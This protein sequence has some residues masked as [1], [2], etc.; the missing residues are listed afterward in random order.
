MKIY[1]A[2]S[3]RAGRGDAPWYARCVQYLE[4]YGQI[5]TEH[6]GDGSL[7]ELGE[8]GKDDNLGHIHS[9]DMA[10]LQT[11]DVVVAEVS[12]PSLGVGYEIAS[13]IFLKK[14]VL[15]LYRIQP[16]T[17]LSGMLEGNPHIAITQFST[18]AQALSAIDSFFEGITD[19]P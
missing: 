19:K 2:G 1:F 13:A 5:L 9:R 14:P 3:I 11:A 7:S 10:W 6:V 17:R 18:E 15:C 12:Q 8:D 4:K 16:G